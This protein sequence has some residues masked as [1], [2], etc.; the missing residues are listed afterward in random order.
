MNWKVGLE[1]NR[2]LQENTTSICNNNTLVST[3]ELF[4]SPDMNST[5]VQCNAH[6]QYSRMELLLFSKF[7]VLTVMTSGQKGVEGKY[8][9]VS[10]PMK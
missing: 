8:M 10:L 4:A 1:E 2:T 7:A 5:P 3:L 9:L 6:K